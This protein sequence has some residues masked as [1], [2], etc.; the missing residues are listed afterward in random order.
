MVFR[1]ARLWGLRDASSL[2]LR[3]TAMPR[4][5]VANGTSLRMR[6]LGSKLASMNDPHVVALI[7]S[8]RHHESVDYG[9]AQPLAFENDQFVVSLKDGK[10]RFE[11]KEHYSTEQ[12]AREAVEPFIRNWRFDA[13][14]RR[15]PDCFVLDFDKAEIIDRSPTPGVIKVNAAPA[16]W[17]FSI[18]SP[19]VTV[20]PPTYPPT[21]TGI[22]SS[23]PDVKTL[24]DR[25]RGYKDGKE[26][27]P[28][29]AYYCFTELLRQAQGGV[30][31]VARRYSISQPVLKKISQLSSIKGGVE[32]RK[33]KGA[34]D[35]FTK[36]EREFL[37]KALPRLILRVAEYHGGQHNIPK[38]TMGD[39]K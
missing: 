2:P 3:P 10:A 26:L 4:T 36:E 33:A 1:R 20:S 17:H 18:P 7:Y 8:V 38:I 22:D 14:L 11:L 12:Q 5:A 15:D 30:A 25:Y 16:R 28:S 24:H 37:E 6:G 23:H 34:N 9:K 19:K 13:E 31:K 35:P 27:L 39:L 29:F 32:A 21:P